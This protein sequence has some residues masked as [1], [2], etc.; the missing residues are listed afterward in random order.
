MSVTY[1]LE[2]MGDSFHVA[3]NGEINT[4]RDVLSYWTPIREK[5]VEQDIQKIYIDYRK[6]VVNLDYHG[7]I[8]LS[9]HAESVNFHLNRFRISLLV[10]PQDLKTFQLFQTPAINRGFNFHISTE[11][12]DAIAWLDKE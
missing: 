3:V 11:K 4:Y 7:M 9:D 1:S 6:T 2:R 12:E 8:E 5:A 10:L